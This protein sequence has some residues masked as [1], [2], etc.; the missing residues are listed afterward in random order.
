MTSPNQKSMRVLFVAIALIAACDLTAQQA[1]PTIYA[2]LSGEWRIR[3]SNDPRYALP[4]ADDHDWPLVTLPWRTA[5]P[6]GEF[7]IRRTV[8]LPPNLG[9]EPL[10]LAVGS[11][12][13]DWQVFANG[14][15]LGSFLEYDTRPRSFLLPFE[16]VRGRTQL[17]VAI[18][19]AHPR[20]LV[21]ALGTRVEDEGPYL[22]APQRVTEMAVQH[23]IGVKQ[24]KL[25]PFVIV[26]S[27]QFVLACSAFAI[28]LTSKHWR[29]FLWLTIYLLLLNFSNLKFVTVTGMG[30]SHPI[31]QLPTAPVLYPILAEVT[32]AALNLRPHLWRAILWPIAAVGLAAMATTSGALL[33]S[34]AFLLVALISAMAAKI[35]W[36]GPRDLRLRALPLWVIPFWSALAFLGVVPNSVNLGSWWWPPTS[37]LSTIG[38]SII[39]AILLRQLASDRKE[40]QRLASE[41]EAARAIQQLLL[42]QAHPDSSN[43]TIDA[44]YLPASEVGGDFYHIRSLPHGAILVAVGD[45]SGKGLKAAMMVSLIMGHLQR[46]TSDSPAEVLDSLNRTLIA[47]GGA[48]FVTCCCASI[49]S[50]GRVTIANAGHVAPY[51]NGVELDL[52]PALPLGISP[53]EQYLDT[54]HTLSVNDTL[55]LLSDGVVEAQNLKGELFGFD[56]TRTIATQPAAEIA[57]SAR[58]FGQTDDITVVT[59]RRTA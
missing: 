42:A 5:V 17:V 25:V 48:G 16:A 1:Q 21:R 2:D 58:A 24:R 30:V 54:A 59:I 12:E 8:T 19:V 13:G 10:A 44:V 49:S 26:S 34:V 36:Q 43:L 20:I 37:T 57:E 4:E 22:L 6:L 28:W 45:V 33:R 53:T 51:H 52:P 7:W 31:W 50:E 15:L 9:A 29:V 32:I 27:M 14:I 11:M 3:M 46:E 18:R 56:R 23:A 39:M 40:K 35:I 38:T 41:F 55:V 47:R